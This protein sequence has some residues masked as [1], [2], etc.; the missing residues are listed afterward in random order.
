MIFLRQAFF[1]LM[2]FLSNISLLLVFLGKKSDILSQINPTEALTSC[3]SGAM[4]FSWQ[5][6]SY[7]MEKASSSTSYKRSEKTPQ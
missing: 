2:K 1:F 3:L 7:K 4:K 6:E 5:F